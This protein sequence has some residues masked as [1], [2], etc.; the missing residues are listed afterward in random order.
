MPEP[1]TPENERRVST[2][3]VRDEA[4]GLETL[5]AFLH[6]SGS[7]DSNVIK[8]VAWRTFNLIR[9]WR[10]QGAEAERLRAERD[11]AVATVEKAL[12][13]AKTIAAERDAARE[14]VKRVRKM[15]SAVILGGTCTTCGHA[16]PCPTVR[17]LDG[18]EADRG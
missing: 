4:T 10:E 15:H 8:D 16:T 9:A 5:C 12:A 17:A 11:T 7:A 1:M 13:D 6:A 14:Q 3:P 2:S 18:A